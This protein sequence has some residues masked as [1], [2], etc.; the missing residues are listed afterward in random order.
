MTLAVAILLAAVALTVLAM[1]VVGYVGLVTG[2]VTIDTGWGRRTRPLGPLTVDI[3]AAREDVY[4]LLVQPYLGPATKALAEKVQ[5]LERS[6]GMVLAAHRT[7]VSGRLVAVTVETVTFTPVERIGFRLLRG[8]VPHVIEEFTLTD[9]P[10]GCRLHYQGEL[11]TDFGIIGAP[12]GRVVARVWHHT[13]SRTMTA[14]KTEAE[15][16]AGRVKGR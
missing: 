6:D 13:V 7:P 16:R 8:P 3:N 5:V 14:V 12:W 10:T 2:A 1:A 4:G 15:R 11:G 9:A